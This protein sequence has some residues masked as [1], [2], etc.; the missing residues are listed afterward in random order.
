MA[1]PGNTLL[2]PL[3]IGLLQNTFSITEF[4]GSAD[5]SD[6]YKFESFKASDKKIQ[7]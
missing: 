2:T 6:Y 5:R 1:D 3:K 7:I 4:V